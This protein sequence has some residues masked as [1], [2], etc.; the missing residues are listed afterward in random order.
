MSKLDE[1]KLKKSHAYFTEAWSY[2]IGKRYEGG[3]GGN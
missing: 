2:M 3:G 1:F